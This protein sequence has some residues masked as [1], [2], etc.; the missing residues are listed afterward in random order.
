[1]VRKPQRDDVIRQSVSA[2]R[3]LWEQVQQYQHAEMIS[4]WA[5]AV[6]RLIITGLRAED[7]RKKGR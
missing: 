1:M 2:P 4:T 6:R 5:E 3:N 7:A